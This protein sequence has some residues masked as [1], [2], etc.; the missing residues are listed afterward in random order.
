MSEYPLKIVTPDG[1]AF[2]GMCSKII[3]RTV[4]GDVCILAGHAEY[5]APLASGRVHVEAEGAW[6]EAFCEEGVLSV[7]KGEV[8][9]IAA[10][11]EWEK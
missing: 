5:M 2:D 4:V 11:F 3:V 1:I 6:R 7:T 9:V 8:T 10:T